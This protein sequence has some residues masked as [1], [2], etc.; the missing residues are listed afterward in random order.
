MNRTARLLHLMGLSKLAIDMSESMMPGV[1]VFA[2]KTF[3]PHYY[4]GWLTVNE[5]DVFEIM[6]SKSPRENDGFEDPYPGSSPGANVRVRAR[7]EDSEEVVW[8]TYDEIEDNFDQVPMAEEESAFDENTFAL[9]MPGD[10]LPPGEFDTNP[11]R[12]S[13]R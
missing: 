4:S 5:N 2:N 9:D 1:R 12:P 6:G 13:V 11:D 8:F 10:A 3:N 7:R